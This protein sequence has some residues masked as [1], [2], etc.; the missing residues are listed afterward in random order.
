MT[1]SSA[2]I[3]EF[4][5]LYGAGSYHRMLHHPVW[6]QGIRQHQWITGFSVELL[7]C[8]WYFFLFVPLP[9][10]SL[11]PDRAG[12]LF[13]EIII[14]YQDRGRNTGLFKS[15][16]SNHLS[17]YSAMLIFLFAYSYRDWSPWRRLTYRQLLTWSWVHARKKIKKCL[18]KSS[19][20]MY[21]TFL[22]SWIV[23]PVKGCMSKDEW[24]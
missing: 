7:W 19:T 2:A 6:W 10:R 11:L 21:Q 9:S 22:S 8:S 24:E 3:N 20:Q 4:T 1:V 15:R 5:P 23:P 18:K 17:F 14:F 16:L 13:S 12:T